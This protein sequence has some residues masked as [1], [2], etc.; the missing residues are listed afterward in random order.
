MNYFLKAGIGAAVGGLVMW[1]LNLPAEI[2]QTKNMVDEISKGIAT[3]D[4]FV[5]IVAE[6]VMEKEKEEEK[7][8]KT[9]KKK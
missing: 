6:R 3:N 9:K 5:D 1:L 8:V 7:I 2:H 4:E